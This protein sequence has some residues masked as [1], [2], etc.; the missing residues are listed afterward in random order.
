MAGQTTSTYDAMLKEFYGVD[1]VTELVKQKAPFLYDCKKS[2]L[3]SADGRRVIAPVHNSRNVGT[4]SRGEGGAL[5]TAGNQGFLDLI[6][7][8][9]FNHLRIFL[10][11]QAMK[12]SRTSEGAFEHALDAEIEYG[13][14]DAARELSRQLQ[15]D[16]TGIL[17]QGVGS[18]SGTT[19]TINHGQNVADNNDVPARFLRKGGL[20]AFIDSTTGVLD[21]AS[22][23]IQAVA[24][25]AANQK[26][27]TVG[28]SYTST[29]PNPYVVNASTLTNT[30]AVDIAYNN[31]FMG[32]LGIV[33]DGTYVGTYFSQSRSTNPILNAYRL[34]LGEGNLTLDVMQQAED[35][36][37]QQSDGEI[38][39][40]Y[41]NHVTR[42][43]YSALLQVM[44]RYTNEM[45]LTPDGG[46]K[47]GMLHKSHIEFNEHPVIV[48]RDVPMGLIHGLNMEHFY[49][50]M[51]TE[52]EW[53]DE[54]GR[55]LLR[56]ATT[57]AY[58]GRYRIFG[59]VANLAPNTNYVISSV[60]LNSAVAAI[61]VAN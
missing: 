30:N 61:N 28:A 41:A 9:R 6:I 29:N 38:Q 2:K 26:S 1:T 36:V 31:D 17:C 35:G 45:A 14:K 12:Q 34:D 37:D 11:I 5:P 46:F 22:N 49:R 43:E 20:I 10:T 18:V 16:G 7:P 32:L 8:Y 21:V 23:S 24:S 15:G 50:F 48:D 52:G 42:R 59:N 54:D 51:L 55:I 60:K 3:V 56:D 33:D 40:L 4:S 58:E 44:K 53:A 47:G 27:F 25:V 13:V 57:D 19:I 39:K